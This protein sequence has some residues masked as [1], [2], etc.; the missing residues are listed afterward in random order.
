MHQYKK[1]LIVG[2]SARGKTT[3]TD[4]LSK[5]ISHKILHLD[6]IYWEE[7]LL[8]F[9]DRKDQLDMLEDFLKENDSWIIEGATRH[10]I[11]PIFKYADIIIYLKHRNFFVQQFYVIKRGIKEGHSLKQILRLVWFLLGRECNI[12][13]HKES[14]L[15]DILRPFNVK[16]YSVSSWKEI[17]RLEKML[18]DNISII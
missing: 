10:L 13:R 4:R 16:V 11:E 17:N 9:R 15:E 12:L 14:R 1:I 8:K 18:V 3:L 7:H 2:D 6:S 5:N